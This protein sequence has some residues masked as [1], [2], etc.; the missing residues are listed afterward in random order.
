MNTLIR[1]RG[2]LPQYVIN[3]IIEEV[4]QNK[5]LPIKYIMSLLSINKGVFKYISKYYYNTLRM[6]QDKF[7]VEFM[8]IV[9]THIKNEYCPLKFIRKL[10]IGFSR[11]I[12]G[13]GKQLLPLTK[14]RFPHLTTLFLV[15]NR[16][17]RQYKSIDTTFPTTITDLTLD[18]R[19]DSGSTE[20][21]VAI[22]E[23]VKPSIKSLSLF[24]KESEVPLYFSKTSLHGYLQSYQVGQ[25][26]KL[27]INTI[28]KLKE[29]VIFC[30]RYKTLTS[31]SLKDTELS[32][33]SIPKCEN[34]Q[35]LKITCQERDI[36]TLITLI[37]QKS[38]IRELVL[39]INQ[40]YYLY[41]GIKTMEPFMFI[42]DLQLIGH[43]NSIRKIINYNSKSSI[44]TS[45]SIIKRE[46]SLYDVIE[47]IGTF[48][49]KNTS[50]KNLVIDAIEHNILP[51]Q[52]LK[53]L[54]QSISK[55]PTL[56]SLTL[57]IEKQND[58][59]KTYLFDHLHQSKSLSVIKVKSTTYQP[60]D[61]MK[62]KHPFVKI[63]SLGN[64]TTY[65]PTK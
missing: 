15:L 58:V 39:T 13:N 47:T 65:M 20:Y 59:V 60:G 9:E 27:Y 53:S 18:L 29:K 24:L 42:M 2:I 19:Y 46:Y 52:I 50:L 16:P 37:N 49:D 8:K 14:T 56:Q 10:V 57:G 48:L 44:L 30:N 40:D 11:D 26:T 28:D 61:S 38:S 7:T 34:L 22:L 32:L 6:G 31:L 41:Y 33:E 45:L 21:I 1:P 25:L 12:P 4:L 23:S 43:T 63:E 35:Y 62:P 54:S 64:I 51:D 17:I 36:I 55:H 3:S 5:N